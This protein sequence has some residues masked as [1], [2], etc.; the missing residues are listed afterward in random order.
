MLGDAAIAC[1]AMGT[2][3]ESFH[4]VLELII[5]LISQ[6]DATVACVTVGDREFSGPVVLG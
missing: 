1:V 5:P 3:S 2:V 6:S 4:S